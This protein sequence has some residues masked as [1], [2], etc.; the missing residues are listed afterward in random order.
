MKNLFKLITSLAVFIVAFSAA[1][2]FLGEKAKEHRYIV[3][4]DKGNELF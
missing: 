2:S 1:V 4:D 3:V